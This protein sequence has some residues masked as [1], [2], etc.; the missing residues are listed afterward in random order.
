[1]GEWLNDDPERL[2]ETAARALRLADQT[3]D[4]SAHDALAL[5]GL[6]LLAR[7][8]KIEAEERGELQETD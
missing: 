2:R 1:M 6:E 8:A 4:T 3:E 7:A 5:Y